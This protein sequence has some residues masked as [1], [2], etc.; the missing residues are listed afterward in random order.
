MSRDAKPSAVWVVLVQ[1]TLFIFQNCNNKPENG[2]MSFLYQ[3]LW[4]SLIKSSSFI[5]L[6]YQPYIAELTLYFFVVWN[7]RNNIY[8]ALRL[9]FPIKKNKNNKKPVE[10]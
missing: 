9:V 3:G 6:L 2:K 4:W 5:S 10:K 1:H 7:D 8:K